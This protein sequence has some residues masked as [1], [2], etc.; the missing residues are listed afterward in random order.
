MDQD[1]QYHPPP[2]ASGEGFFLMVLMTFALKVAED[3]ARIWPRCALKRHSKVNCP[4]EL[5][6]KLPP[7]APREAP[8]DS[9]GALRRCRVFFFITLKPRVE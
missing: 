6:P 8:S 9:K 4:S 5:C 1:E 3:K 7:E 2:L